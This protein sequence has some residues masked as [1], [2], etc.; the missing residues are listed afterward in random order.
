MN[1]GESV[2][3][4]LLAYELDTSSSDLT[5]AIYA[6]RSAG[7]PPGSNDKQKQKHFFRFLVDNLF[8]VLE[9]QSQN[10][11]ITTGADVLN[12]FTVPEFYF[13][14]RQNLPFD[15][16]IYADGKAYLENRFNGINNLVVYAGS[17]WWWEQVQTPTG[18]NAAI[19]NTAPVLSNGTLVCDWNKKFLSPID[20]LGD[21][22]ANWGPATHWDANSDA[23]TPLYV[24]SPNPYF[25]VTVNGVSVTLGVEVCLDHAKKY[26]K[27]HNTG[28]LDAHV[29]VCAGM[30]PKLAALACRTGGVF[31]RCEGGGG[32]GRQRSNAGTFDG[33][34]LP[35]NV[36]A[37]TYDSL[38]SR[39]QGIDER[40]KIYDPITINGP[41]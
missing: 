3:I 16:D 24:G 9:D 36:N 27:N 13:K 4:Q 14:D 30:P 19:H 29:L 21:P 18:P 8:D 32:W 12:V 28:H 10:G 33:T 31:L 38:A 7:P 39:P 6:A 41:S 26:L 17:A 35:V 20:G 5:E 11:R 15:S 40:V 2:K 22:S 37:A 23:I 1:R 34:H 25:T